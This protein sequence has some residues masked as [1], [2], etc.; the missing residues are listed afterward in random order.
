MVSLCPGVF[1]DHLNLARENSFSEFKLAL[2]ATYVEMLSFQQLPV[3]S[4]FVF[5]LTS[6]SFVDS[7]G[8]NHLCNSTVSSSLAFIMCTLFLSLN[9]KDCL[10]PLEDA[11][12]I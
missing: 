1:V 7:G 11:N 10:V 3:I 5:A 9:N 8:I 12:T 6:H 4:F 2:D